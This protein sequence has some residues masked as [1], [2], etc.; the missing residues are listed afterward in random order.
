MEKITAFRITDMT[1]SGFKSFGEKT[2][3]SFGNPTVI[4]GGN[5]RG[6]SSIADAIAFAITGFPF[7]G[8]RKLDRLHND[9]NPELYI[10]MRF[11]NE[12]GEHHELIR[13]RSKNRMTIT[14]DG[15]E[16]RQRDLTDMFGERDIFL[17]IFNPLY[18]IE[19]LGDEGK[20]M[21]ERYLPL[22]PQDKV[23]E[24]LSPSTREALKGLE[25]L[26]P[27]GHIK[28]LRESIREM[29]STINYLQGQQDMADAQYQ[30]R[31]KAV[32]DLSMQAE[33]LRSEQKA[34]EEKQFCGMDISKM[35]NELMDLSARY[36]EVLC[37]LRRNIQETDSRRLE[38]S[39]KLGERKAAAYE[40]KYTGPIA[41]TAAKVRELA[42]QYNKETQL[43]AAIKPGFLCPTCRRKVTEVDIPTIQESFRTNLEAII[44]EGRERKAQLKE[45]QELERKSRDTFEQFKAEDIARLEAEADALDREKTSEKCVDHTQQGEQMHA[46]I[47]QL[48]SDLEFGKLSQEEYERLKI[49]RESLEKVTAELAALQSIAIP[50][51]HEVKG[52]ILSLQDQI[53][54]DKEQLQHLA[55]YISKR[56]EMTFS[57]LKVNRVAISLYDVV[58]STGEIKDTFRFTYNDRRY[59]RLSLSEKIRAGMEVSE[60]LKRLTGRVYPTF[61]DNMESVDD[62]NNIVPTGQLIMAKCIANTELIVRPV[63]PVVASERQCAA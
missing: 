13:T 18:F 49:Y 11:L 62:L 10:R 37:A 30:A 60:M 27:E 15:Y 38:L 9:E 17:S 47:Q 46:R 41:E 33:T 58:K 5:G 20:Q 50:P 56:A 45:L 61:V 26:S 31:E 35:Q 32:S 55:F 19:E 63:S 4:T 43:Y 6:K 21:L 22:V 52:K 54:A 8:E 25:L 12:S 23:M 39:R 14:Y 40:P 53:K 16:I 3:V 7:F 48:T 51:S 24:Q 34:L 57:K 28:R 2:Q 44:S 1:L 29:E 42:M 36:S 59:D